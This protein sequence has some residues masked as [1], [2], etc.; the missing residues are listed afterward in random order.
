M[1]AM[2]SLGERV[3]STSEFDRSSLLPVIGKLEDEGPSGRPI[4]NQS[5]QEMEIAFSSSA[6]ISQRMHGRLAKK[7]S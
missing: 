6:N 7:E 4:W 5:M 2:R 3:L 1:S